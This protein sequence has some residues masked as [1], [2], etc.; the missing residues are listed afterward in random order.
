MSDEEL[1]EQLGALARASEADG[2]GSS[3]QPSRSSMESPHQKVQGEALEDDEY[4]LAEIEDES[5]GN[6]ALTPLSSVH[7][8]DDASPYHYHPTGSAAG[9]KHHEFR[10]I[11]APVLMT[12]GVMLLIPAIWAIMVLT[13]A[14][15]PMSDRPDAP[16]MAK[17][18]LICWPLALTLIIPAVL[19]FAQISASRKKARRG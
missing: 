3:D 19:L 2:V 14:R 10:A 11:A 7:Q 6:V 8:S 4:V 1:G 5:G 16:T 15:V 17:V 12:V 9:Q 13:G 18:M